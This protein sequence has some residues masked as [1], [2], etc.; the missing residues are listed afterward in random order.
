M[1][2]KSTFLKFLFCLAF[3]LYKT[4]GFS[5]S[6]NVTVTILPPYD[7]NLFTY[8]DDESK[9][10]ITLFNNSASSQSVKI[11]GTFLST[12]S[13]ISLSTN[14]NYQPPAPIV[15]AP[16]D[17]RM[18]SS[19]DLYHIFPDENSIIATGI[20][21]EEIIRTRRLPANNYQLC[22]T[23]YDYNSP[24]HTVPLSALIPSGCSAP[25]RVGLINSPQMLSFGGISCG[26]RLNYMDIQG[27]N[28][29]W[30]IPP[31]FPV[32]GRY[33]LEM[34]ELYPENRNANDAFESATLPI[35]FNDSVESSN[36]Y[37][38]SMGNPLMEPGRS[39]AIRV[40]VVD[41][42]GGL[43]FAN[44]GYSP[45]CVIR[46]GENN[47]GSVT[48]EG[49]YPINSEY[50]PWRYFPITVKF[51]PY[52]DRLYQFDFNL[53]LKENGTS[54]Y[55]RHEDLRWPDGPARS[56]TAAARM[57]IVEDAS[58]YIPVNE[59]NAL[60]GQEFLRGATYRYNV[61]GYFLHRTTGESA[62]INVNCSDE[63]ISG[64]GV[65][66]NQS[67]SD[68]SIQEPGTITLRFQTADF[69]T[70]PLPTFSIVSS[71]TS[72]RP[73]SNFYNQG[74]EERYK[75]EVSR[76]RSFATIYRS[77][78]QKFAPRV[79]L[80][81]AIDNNNLINDSVYRSLNKSF[82][83]TDTGEYFWRVKWLVD[84][85]DEN[86]AA[87]AT[88]PIWRFRI[89]T[90]GPEIIPDI[91]PRTPASCLAD[92]ETPAR[93]D[94]TSVS[95][96]AA[97]GIV[98]VGKFNM[99][100]TEINWSGT[101]ASGR[102][103][104]R[105]PFMNAPVKVSFTSIQINSR[106]ELIGGDIF[107][108]TDNSTL[109]PN[110]LARAVGVF[111]GIGEGQ[112]QQI[113]E[114]MTTSNRLVS[115]LVGSEPVGMPLGIDNTIDG[116]R[117][118]VG[119]MGCKFTATIATLN[120]LV[121]LDV[122]ELHGWL[123]L[124]ANDICFHPGGL[125]MGQGKLFL[126]L[127]KTLS[128]TDDITLILKSPSLPRD[129]GSYVSWDCNGFRE[130]AIS[131]L[132]RFNRRLLVPDANDGSAGPGQVEAR[133][134]FRIQRKGNWIGGLDIDPFQVTGLPG[135]GF[136][137]S[138]AYLDFSDLQNGGSMVFPEGYGGDKTITWKGFYL[139][140]L[141]VRLPKEFKT[142]GNPTQRIAGSINNVLIDGTG[143]SGRFAIENL[144]RVDDGNL[145]GWAYSLDSVYLSMVSNDF[146]N[147]GLSGEIRLPISDRDE[148]KYNASLN[149]SS[150]GEF[151]FE[152]RIQPKDSFRAQ[153]WECDLM[154][155]PTS[156]IS[157]IADREGFAASTDLSGDISISGTR[158]G[159]GGAQIEGLGFR[160][161]H[162]QNFRLSSRGPNYISVG[163]FSFAS[164]QHSAGG[165]PLSISGINITSREGPSMMEFD[166]SPG[167]RFG[168][169][170]VLNL[171]LTGESSGFRASGKIALLGKLQ[172]SGE[173]QGWTFSGI[174]LDSIAIGGS[175]GCVTIEGALAFY[176]SHPV[177]GKGIKGY[178]RVEM[179][180][181][182]SVSATVQF[183]EVRGFRYW[184]VDAMATWSPGVTLFT[185]VD[186]RGL[187]GGAWYHMS[188][189]APV[190]F[191]S[192]TNTSGPQS[193]TAGAT[194]SGT[195]YVPN[196]AIGLGFK[197]MVKIGATGGSSAYHGLITLG[198]QFIERTGG[199]ERIYLRGDFMFMT[200]SNNRADAAVA[201]DFE[202]NYNF[203]EEVFQAN[204]SVYV[205]VAGILV[206]VNPNNL[207]GRMEIYVSPRT[208]HIFVGQPT[209]PVGLRLQIGS[210]RI[211]EARFYFMVGMGLPPMPPL[212]DK[213]QRAFNEMRY[214]I[215][216]ER[217]IT[218]LE[219][220]DGF[221]MGTSLDI[222]PLS[223]EIMPFYARIALGFGFD[224]SVKKYTTRCEG[225]APGEIMGSN[226]WYARGQIFGY[227]EASMGLFVDL[228]F[229]KG[230]FEILNVQAAAYLQGG[231]PNPN[232]VE[233]AIAGRFSILNGAVQ[234]NC[235]FAFSQG[236]KCV[237]PVENPLRGQE[238]VAVLTP[239]SFTGNV[240]C[241]VAPTAL[242]NYSLNTEF[243]LSSPD[244]NGRPIVRTFRVKEKETKLNVIRGNRP[245][246][247]NKRLSENNTLITFYP[248]TFLLANTGH[249][250]Q[251][252]AFAEESKSGAWA[253]SK[254]LENR[255]ISKRYMTAFVTGARPNKIREQDVLYSF[256]YHNQRFFLQQECKVGVL[257]L[258]INYRHLFDRPNTRGN[259]WTYK[260]VFTPVDGGAPQEAILN[261][262]LTNNLSFNIPALQNNKVYKVEIVAQN[263]ISAA[264]R[265][266]SSSGFS[267]KS[268]PTIRQ[269]M[270]SQRIG[271]STIET[272]NKS[273]SGITV[274]EEEM[275]ILYTFHFKTSE[276]NSVAEKFR[277]MTKI[278]TKK[279]AWGDLESIDEIFT[280]E[281][282]DQF[283][284][285]PM[286]Y[287][288]QGVDR[289]N[290]PLISFDAVWNTR[291]NIWM[292]RQ[293]YFIYGFK[294]WLVSERFESA[295][296]NT[297]FRTRRYGAPPRGPV[298]FN[299]S[300]VPKPILSFGE[301]NP[302]QLANGSNFTPMGTSSTGKFGALSNGRS[303]STSNNNIPIFYG[304]TTQTLLNRIESRNMARS[305][306][307]YYYPEFLTSTQIQYLEAV[308]Y[309]PYIRLIFGNYPVNVFYNPP[310]CQGPDGGP[311]HT[312]NI[313][314]PVR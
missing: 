140:R 312:F 232:W 127:D 251:T 265:S 176:N 66:V 62:P 155:L 22:I 270:N 299:L 125:N 241:G 186:L 83:F 95:T 126:P 97:R 287:T 100:L 240:D 49:A 152:F 154:L 260:V 229:V 269:S 276:F 283:D 32:G 147:A 72:A 136:I 42:T 191:S 205:N 170:F 294:D 17:T 190:S 98:I 149:R 272:S 157:I 143:F 211:A 171:S 123:S 33:V 150:A 142:Y 314:L 128:Y 12:D 129:S 259:S 244:M 301:K 160:G 51:S 117:L 7:P 308:F 275:T 131:G 247:G 212:P 56:Q 223:L 18:L 44:G 63:F 118:T 8:T 148:L 179:Q 246:G 273:M 249:T 45:P 74:I 29:N 178:L 309:E 38:Y 313:V 46:Y 11:K 234:G 215:N 111:T 201:A 166:Q 255:E 86:S 65:P 189:P 290:M 57:T 1:K 134:G 138:E 227:F 182:I 36:S 242:Y 119:I 14:P 307:A 39:Y 75:I 162:F 168:I 298:S 220:G 263:T 243:S 280:G 139:K 19:S 114:W 69:P 124:G 200:E 41:P 78:S 121:S 91:P 21:R 268:S 102:G 236:Q 4:I 9:V 31:E 231:F 192:I 248:D 79:D 304:L 96:A 195:S 52:D 161:I 77:F 24:Q 40:K 185:G 196:I 84:D 266:A 228:F 256:P 158:G 20:S 297:N 47:S 271:N 110:S 101:N 181:M 264:S 310:T 286:V 279:I 167:S 187:G 135:W 208:W 296:V 112:G 238:I 203:V 197:V 70:L 71:G 173:R 281:G 6:I 164:E 253:I 217:D 193:A 103:H 295:S 120:A 199:I 300:Y 233:G 55:T 34:I 219:K 213:I 156:R 254:D 237:P 2:I 113:N 35:F 151:S 262:V 267:T 258:K 261:N 145:G 5:Q 130:L 137:S 16:G 90:S 292:E 204:F 141:A 222:G 277:A 133:F 274:R 88:G 207:A 25:F 54:V 250:W 15:L 288:Q 159:S 68:N 61:G 284:V 302:G 180:P 188:E 230:R 27:F 106:N 221:A 58:R 115:Q 89:G 122:P 92:C 13:R 108:E 252:T 305:V 37:F 76:T 53:D 144:I 153:I 202:V 109:V 10:V 99:T 30:T 132:V 282:F 165:F 210:T 194:S 289:I 183:G 224:L 59:S 26:E 293:Q 28:I 198:A 239:E 85:A 225:M 184:Y 303:N 306:I 291:N 226:G 177:F 23:V 257:A 104:I 81:Q 87:Y 245:V 163:A 50:I 82:D 116:Q 169:E 206:G 235:H 285:K 3:L 80:K 216:I 60:A 174:N 73:A 43:R 311:S 105:V 175:V 209:L 172:L 278:E 218:N 48:L 67:P 93:T 94:R 146:R 107:T 214:P 64:I